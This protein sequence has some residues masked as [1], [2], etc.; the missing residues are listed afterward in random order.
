MTKKIQYL[1]LGVEISYR[2][3]PETARH[4]IQQLIT[5]HYLAL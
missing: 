2:N 4:P 1:N 5:Y 3:Q